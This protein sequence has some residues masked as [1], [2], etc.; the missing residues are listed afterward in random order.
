MAKKMTPI[1]VRLASSNTGATP[2]SASGSH[3]MGNVPIV[4]PMDIDSP[5]PASTGIGNGGPHPV[6]PMVVPPVPNPNVTQMSVPQFSPKG[7]DGSPSIPFKPKQ[8]PSEDNL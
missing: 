3:P 7:P 5:T 4:M 2:V 8:M 1:S 6:R